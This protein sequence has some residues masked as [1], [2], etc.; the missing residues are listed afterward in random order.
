MIVGVRKE[1]NGT[2]YINKVCYSKKVDVVL[3]TDDFE[4][5]KAV[6]PSSKYEYKVVKEPMQ[7]SIEVVD[8]ES[9]EIKTI[10][11]TELVDLVM[12]TKNVFSKDTLG[13]APYN[14]R[15]VDIDDIFEDCVGADFDENL[16]FSESKYNAR[17]QKQK[18][19]IRIEEIKPRLEQLSQDLIQA[20]AGAVFDDIDKRKSEFQSLHN[21]F[22]SLHS[23]QWKTLWHEQY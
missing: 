20:Q 14:F 12:V 5:F 2:I 11:T 22:K 6:T 15:P 9:G 23:K 18:D 16:N 10:T 21:E 4:K 13:R 17:K 1:P 3:T 19:E 7:K 8:E